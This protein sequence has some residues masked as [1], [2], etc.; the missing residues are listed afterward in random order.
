[1]RE[2]VSAAVIKV[3][4]YEAYHSLPASALGTALGN[5]AEVEDPAVAVSQAETFVQVVE[6]CQVV[7]VIRAATLI[8]FV[9][10]YQVDS[11]QAEVAYQVGP[12]ALVEEAF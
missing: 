1:M 7:V 9:A 4:A 3:A 8:L 11:C 12:S 2:I 10:A 6:A 5:L